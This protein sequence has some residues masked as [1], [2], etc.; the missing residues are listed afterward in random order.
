MVGMLAGSVFANVYTFNIPASAAVPTVPNA[1]ASWDTGY[2]MLTNPHEYVTGMDLLV[3]GDMAGISSVVTVK[4]YADNQLLGIGKF[5]ASGGTDNVGAFDFHLGSNNLSFMS[6][7]NGLMHNSTKD[8]FLTLVA[9]QTGFTTVSGGHFNIT[10]A[11]PEPGTMSLLGMGLLG[12]IG[13]VKR[14]FVA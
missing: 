7:L 2:G 5:L 4:A 12:M 6:A 8:V 11:V 13:F 3:Y 9:D 10:T 1:V 14:K